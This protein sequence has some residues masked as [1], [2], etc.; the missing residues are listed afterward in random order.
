MSRAHWL[1][2]RPEMESITWDIYLGHERLRNLQQEMLDLTTEL[3]S[4]LRETMR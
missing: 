1:Y 3:T 4:R 2:W